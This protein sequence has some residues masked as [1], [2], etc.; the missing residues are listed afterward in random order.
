MDDIICYIESPKESTV[1]L[2]KLMLVAQNSLIKD[3]YNQINLISM[4]Q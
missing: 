3:Q 1:E 4:Y 2:L